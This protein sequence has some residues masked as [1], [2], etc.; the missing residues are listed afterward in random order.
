[1]SGIGDELSG[2][3]VRFIHPGFA[4][5]KIGCFLLLQGSMVWLM[6]LVTRALLMSAPS[7]Y[8]QSGVPPVRPVT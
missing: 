7:A 2:W 3:A 1:M 5:M 4:F 8:T 6:V